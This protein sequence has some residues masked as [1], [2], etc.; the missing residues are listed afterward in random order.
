M[1]ASIVNPMPPLMAADYLKSFVGLRVTR[2]VRYSWWPAEEAAVECNVDRSAV[3]SLTAGP[4]SV[5][6]ESGEIM[7]VASDPAINSVIVWD[8]S[9]RC[10]TSLF[11]TLDQDEELFPIS[12]QDE[13]YASAFWREIVGSVLIELT[14]LKK[15]VMSA[16]EEGVPSELGLRFVF[17]NGKSFIA[18]H[19][20]H[21]GSDDFSV[22]EEKK[23]S[24]TEL[25]ELEV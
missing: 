22:L 3:F 18:S 14:V 13:L 23:I 21:D 19:G 17:Q 2:L 16:K 24:I 8:E 15:R 1:K 5:Q 6:F 25:V 9:A 10:H 7:G 11:S 20:L 4:L 12:A